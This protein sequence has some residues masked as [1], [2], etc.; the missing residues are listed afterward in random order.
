MESDWNHD[1]GEDDLIVD[2]IKL[3]CVAGSLRM[4]AKA[5]EFGPEQVAMRM[6]AKRAGMAA[7]T[8][9]EDWT[10]RHPAKVADDN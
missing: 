3:A 7:T 2:A 8:L 5:L 1:F 9:L 10:N 4:S 6:A